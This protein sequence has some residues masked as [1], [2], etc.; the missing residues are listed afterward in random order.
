MSDQRDHDISMPYRTLDSFF[1]AV[2]PIRYP[3]SEGNATGFYFNDDNQDDYL[4]TNR[5]ALV[6]EDGQPLN[7]SVRIYSRPTTDVDDLQPHDIP[8]V[9]DGEP[10]WIEHPA[11]HEIDVAAL[12]LNF[13]LEPL[14]T[15][16]LHSGMFPPL[17]D[18]MPIVQNVMIL[19]Y[20]I[21]GK[22]PYP[23][24]TRDGLIASPYGLAFSEL[25]CFAVDANLHSGT[26][27][28]PVFSV[29]LGI[30]HGANQLGGELN[31]IGIHSETLHSNHPPEEGPLNLNYAWYIE[32]LKDMITIRSDD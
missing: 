18:E 30:E 5:H 8:L 14:S 15:V 23:P 3:D 26:S 29:P 31:L 28:S 22:H 17:S 16:A 24:I 2:T 7:D 11:S 25:P 6:S 1:T 27:G 13:D 21:L 9:D 12:P 4:I 10:N 20:P 19:G 32:L